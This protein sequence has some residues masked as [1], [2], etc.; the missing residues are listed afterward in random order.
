MEL[1]LKSSWVCRA[2]AAWCNSGKLAPFPAELSGLHA[3]R[4][5]ACC[6]VEFPHA[7]I[8]G[9][10]A[11]RLHFASLLTAHD[12]EVL[13]AKLPKVGTELL[14]G[15]G[16]PSLKIARGLHVFSG[17]GHVSLI[18]R[19]M[20]EIMQVHRLIGIELQ[21]QR[22]SQM[23]K[24]PSKCNH[25]FGKGKKKKNYIGSDPTST[26]ERGPHWCTDHMTSPPLRLRKE[27]QAEKEDRSSNEKASATT[28]M[29]CMDTYIL[30]AFIC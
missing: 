28:D 1:Q 14:R 29:E 2:L 19:R 27:Q 22:D 20:P 11:C 10:Q 15:K 3:A 24:H 12:P 18:L 13:P 17:E 6:R 9:H 7:T 25:G 16:F 26:K 21:L 4:H 8:K 30:Y 23:L 5:S